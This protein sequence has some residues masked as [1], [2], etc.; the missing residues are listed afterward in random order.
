MHAGAS[1]W[2]EGLR[3]RWLRHLGFGVAVLLAAG[4]AAVLVGSTPPTSYA[5]GSAWLTAV[6]LCAGL[7]LIGAGAVTTS[8]GGTQASPASASQAVGGLV[9][10]AGLAWLAPLWNGWSPGPDLVRSVSMV[11]APFLLPLLIHLVAIDRRVRARAQAGLV[12]LAYVMTSATVAV[13]AVFDHP[14][15]DPDCWA[16][17]TV[18]VFYWRP[19]PELVRVSELLW[20]WS[21]VGLGLAAAG[22]GCRRLLSASAPGRARV[23]PVLVPAILATLAEVSYILLQALSVETP[24]DPRSTFVFVVRALALTALAGGLLWSSERLWRRRRAMAQ[25]VEML[26]ATD[27]RDALSVALSGSSADAGLQVLYWLDGPGHYVDASGRRVE[28][29]PDRA[30]TSLT[31]GGRLVAAVVHDHAAE[32]DL[33][34]DA[35]LGAAARLAIDNERLRAEVLAQLS[36]LRAS[37]ARIVAAADEARVRIERDLHDGTQQSLISMLFELRLALAESRPT[38]DAE[39]TARL[40]CTVAVAE[41]CVVELRELAHGIFPAVLDESGLAAALWTLTDSAGLPVELTD[42]PEKRLSPIAERTAYALV[43]GVIDEAVRQG[44]PALRVA[45]RHSEEAVVVEVDGA[46]GEDYQHLEDR[47]GATGGELVET[48]GRLR[49]VIPCAS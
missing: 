8:L 15:R 5:A 36:A 21:A 29:P 35:E 11:V 25:L 22:I 46:P 23:A 13:R 44:S 43:K 2:T 9:A 3:G 6:T 26:S 34:L 40:E 4:T 30:V 24:A 41:E 27:G 17:C 14:F 12:T 7:G 37:R 20:T 45:V 31:R 16:N 39:R 47:V 28:L 10:A 33:L 32:E 1:P 48:A 49:A 18:N 38:D 42:L 19:F